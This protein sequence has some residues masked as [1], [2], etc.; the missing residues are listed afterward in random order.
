[1]AIG[2]NINFSMVVTFSGAAEEA[3]ELGYDA[4]FGTFRHGPQVRVYATW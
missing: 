4:S 3:T 1:V 2:Y